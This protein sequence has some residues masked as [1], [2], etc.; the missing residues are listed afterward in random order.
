MIPPEDFTDRGI[1]YLAI[2]IEFIKNPVETLA[3]FFPIFDSRGYPLIN[4]F[5]SLP[6]SFLTTIF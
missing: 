1:I 4:L 2:A 5:F 3:D 6:E